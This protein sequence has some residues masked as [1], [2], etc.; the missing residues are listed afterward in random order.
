MA[1]GHVHPSA[2]HCI[3][4][5]ILTPPSHPTS[6]STI[7]LLAAVSDGVGS[8]HSDP[9]DT[10]FHSAMLRYPPQLL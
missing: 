5:L 4:T 9:L 6:V 2:A 7:F 1:V 3:N 10:D 8:C